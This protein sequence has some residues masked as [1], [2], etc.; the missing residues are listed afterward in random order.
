MRSLV[1]ALALGFALPVRAELTSPA[2]RPPPGYAGQQYVDS[3]GCLFVRAGQDPKQ[4]DWLPR[5]T[6]DGKPL[7]GN[8]PSGQRVP[9]VEDGTPV[10]ADP[11]E[12]A[13]LQ[14]A[15]GPQTDAMTQSGFFVAVGSFAVSANADA[16]MARLRALN[17]PAVSG[18]IAGGSDA[19]LTVFAGPFPDADQ[20]KRA[21]S[22]LA[23]AGFPD[24]VLI[25]P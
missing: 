12:A 24:A 18:R 2:E 10:S 1:L 11:A 17:L 5:V 14:A 23:G 22:D 3:K 9:V 21:L 4:D 7:C 20:A 19:L 8:P 16:A 6:R 13:P 25:A 15:T